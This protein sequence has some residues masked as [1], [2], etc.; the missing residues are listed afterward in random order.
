MGATSKLLR[1]PL[2]I[3]GDQ[4]LP[5]HTQNN[6]HQPEGAKKKNPRS[7][8]MALTRYD[9]WANCQNWSRFLV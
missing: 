5:T 4:L 9:D 3:F 8:S 1:V 6:I 7:L 2:F